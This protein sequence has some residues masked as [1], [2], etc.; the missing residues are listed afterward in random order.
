M[1][2]STAPAISSY[3][4]PSYKVCFLAVMLLCERD[5]RSSFWL[6]TAHSSER[7]LR[8]TLADRSIYGP[9]IPVPESQARQ[10]ELLAPVPAIPAW[11]ATMHGCPTKGTRCSRHYLDVMLNQIYVLFICIILYKCI[12]YPYN[13]KIIDFVLSLALRCDCLLLHL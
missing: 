9:P 4:D 1:K 12:S 2:G 3:A 5:T 7:Q 10:P 13:F 8:A 6:T 11:R